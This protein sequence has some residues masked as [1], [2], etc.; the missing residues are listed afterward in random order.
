MKILKLSENINVNLELAQ[1]NDLTA[2]AAG[3]ETEVLRLII[4]G[5]TKHVTMPMVAMTSAIGRQIILE[6]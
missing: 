3:T 6:A 5:R 1:M 4:Q 2:P